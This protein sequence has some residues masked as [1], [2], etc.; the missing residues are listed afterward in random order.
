MS[1]ELIVSQAV[2]TGTP[3]KTTE[4]IYR[5]IRVRPDLE[6]FPQ[7]YEVEHALAALQKRGTVARVWR[8]ASDDKPAYA[9]WWRPTQDLGVTA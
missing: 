9:V 7:K 8:P 3:G 4:E 6:R 2:P 1:W 5:A